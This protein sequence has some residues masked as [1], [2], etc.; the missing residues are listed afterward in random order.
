VIFPLLF[1]FAQ[2][3]VSESLLPSLA[4]SRA[5]S[6]T[7]EVR[8]LGDRAVDAQVEP[9]RESGSLAALSGQAGLVIRLE[10]GEQKKVKLNL[11]EVTENAWA[12]VRE[13]VPNR[14]LAPVLAITGQTDCVAG[15]RVSSAVRVVA[16]PSTNP[17]F[18]GDVG[19]MSGARLVVVNATEGVAVVT[20]CYSGGTLVSNPNVPGGAALTPLCTYRFREQVG[21][22]SARQFPVM[23]EGSS[24]FSLHTRGKGIA[25]QMLRL[26]DAGTQLFQVDSSISFGK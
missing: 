16:H 7:I 17:W 9:H 8:N 6:T 11:P 18:E 4:Y 5:C 23:H 10:A 15:D 20:G 1:L 14:Q 22:F 24:H 13:M 26:L 25:L 3:R 12:A 19:E 2:A 21:P